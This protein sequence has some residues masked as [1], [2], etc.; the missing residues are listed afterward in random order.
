M[1]KSWIQ[2]AAATNTVTVYIGSFQ[3]EMMEGG[4]QAVKIW[5]D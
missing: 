1:A 3:S 4:F 2:I 5:K